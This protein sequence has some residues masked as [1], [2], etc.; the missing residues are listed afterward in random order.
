MANGKDINTTFSSG[1]A[2]RVTFRDRGY[3]SDI[4]I[5]SVRTGEDGQVIAVLGTIRDAA[6]QSLDVIINWDNVLSV[7]ELP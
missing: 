4:R 7:E 3:I 5:H 2:Y 6:N 1:V